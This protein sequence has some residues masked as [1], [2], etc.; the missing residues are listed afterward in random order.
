[1]SGSGLLFLLNLGF[2]SR[3]AV[4]SASSSSAAGTFFLVTWPLGPLPLVFFCSWVATAPVRIDSH[5]LPYEPTPV[6]CPHCALVTLHMAANPLV[7]RRS[8]RRQQRMKKHC[9][10]REN[11]YFRFFCGMHFYLHKGMRHIC[12]AFNQCAEKCCV[13]SH[14]SRLVVKHM[15]DTQSFGQ[16]RCGQQKR[17]F[18]KMPKQ[19]SLLCPLF[20]ARIRSALGA[21]KL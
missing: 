1:M 3:A 8:I 7:F 4:L 21:N 12:L 19:S 15:L 13:F 20:T 5:I 18:C 2:W 10:H 9:G 11:M 17:I 16:T 14:A 6:Y